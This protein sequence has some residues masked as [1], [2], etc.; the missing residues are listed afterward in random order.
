MQ[1][2]T[3]A[4]VCHDMGPQVHPGINVL[5]ILQA[6][7]ICKLSEGTACV[8]CTAGPHLHF[9][10]ALLEELG[11]HHEVV[12]LHP[13]HIP[14]LVVLQQHLRKPAHISR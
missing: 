3:Q 7:S 13:H 11:Q 8:L 12:V 14:R 5:H 2:E 1:I 10:L 6:N 9:G 4:S